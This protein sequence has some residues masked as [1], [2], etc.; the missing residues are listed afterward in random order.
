MRGRL[1]RANLESVKSY[2]AILCAA[3]L[4]SPAW[5]CPDSAPAHAGTT[6][7]VRSLTA[8]IAGHTPYDI[9]RTRDDPPEIRFC[10]TGETILYED[11]RVTVE[12]PL[13]AAYDQISRRIYLIAPWQ[14]ASPEDQ[15]RLL[16]ELIHDIQFLNADWPCPEAAEPEAYRLT[17]AWMAEAGLVANFDWFGIYLMSRC[18]AGIHP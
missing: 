9:A 14:P 13:R 17:A 7:L 15:A 1:G 12:P 16:H 18:P 6:A 11:N 2:P 10:L 4:A 8:W 5:S 3:A